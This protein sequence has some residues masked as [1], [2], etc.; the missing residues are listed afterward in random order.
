MIVLKQNVYSLYIEE[1]QNS[2]R[3]SKMATNI[4]DGRQKLSVL[5]TTVKMLNPHIFIITFIASF[6]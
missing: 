3:V 1:N 2:S 6:Q 4:Q 5:P